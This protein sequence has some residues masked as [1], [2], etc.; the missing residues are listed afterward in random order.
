MLDFDPIQHT[1]MV[2]IINGSL[3]KWAM[4]PL[5]AEA[6]R[7]ADAVSWVEP[8]PP[9]SVRLRQNNEKQAKIDREMRVLQ[10]QWAE[11]RRE[12]GWAV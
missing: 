6:E 5:D 2:R 3:T 11:F 7:I 1:G 12:H 4:Y 9:M 10:P 8:T